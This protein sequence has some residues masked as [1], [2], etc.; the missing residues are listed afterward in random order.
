LPDYA[1]TEHVAAELADGVLTVRVPKHERAKPRK[2][3]ISVSGSDDR[4]QLHESNG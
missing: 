2:V 4:K 1:D 3:S